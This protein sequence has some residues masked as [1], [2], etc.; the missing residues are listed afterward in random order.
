MG[1]GTLAFLEL[2]RP[3]AQR[4]HQHAAQTLVREVRLADECLPAEEGNHTAARNHHK[5][6]GHNPAIQIA[7]PSR[8][9]DRFQTFW[10]RL[11]WFAAE[12]QGDRRSQA[13]RRLSEKSVDSWDSEERKGVTFRDAVTRGPDGLG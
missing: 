12:E 11:Y 1:H 8:K 13:G 3:D 4:R 10:L 5:I 2:V 7:R 6:G 9:T